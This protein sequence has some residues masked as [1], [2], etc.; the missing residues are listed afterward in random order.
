MGYTKAGDVGGA[1]IRRHMR[2]KVATGSRGEPGIDTM[3]M[4]RVR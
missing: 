4:S 2:S 3:G 1:G